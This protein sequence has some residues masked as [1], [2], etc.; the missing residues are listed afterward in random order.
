MKQGKIYCLKD[1][2]TL[3]V[4]YVGFTRISLSSRFSQHKHEA[5]KKNNLSHCYNWFRDCVSKGKIPLIELLESNIP[6]EK[7]EEKEQFWINSYTNLT[8]QKQGGCGVHLNTNKKGRVR[9]IDAKK[10][11]IVQLTKS[12][13]FVKEWGSIVEAEKELLGKLTG[14][15][16]RAVRTKSTALDFF[17]IKKKDYFERIN[18]S[19]TGKQWTKVYLFCV[20]T[21]KLLKVYEKAS[22]LSRELNVV[23]SLITQ[24]LKKN[25]VL[26][27]I[28]FVS[29]VENPI[30]Y[31]KNLNKYLITENS[32]DIVRSLEETSR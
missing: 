2:F 30:E 23:P 29:R 7:W 6:I 17:W 5:I 8:N 9:S 18:Y 15:I 32:E 11:A 12:N 21:K 25:L 4:R 28:Y 13:S 3:E 20:T 14:N 1:P 26:K 27:N 10:I 24:A 16:S 31:P 19:F 22:D